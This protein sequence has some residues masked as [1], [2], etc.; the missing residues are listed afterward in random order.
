MAVGVLLPA[1]WHSL[2]A[3]LIAAMCVGSTFMVITMVGLQEAQ[4]MVGSAGAKRQMAAMTASFALGQLIG[5]LF[6]SLTHQW[7]GATLEFALVMGTLGLLA[8]AVPILRLS[9]AGGTQHAVS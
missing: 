2:A 9:A 4:A 8:G 7:F 6:F 5:P 3:I 1:L